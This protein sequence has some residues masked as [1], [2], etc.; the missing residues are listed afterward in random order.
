MVAIFD[1]VLTTASVSSVSK[2]SRRS[3]AFYA[4]NERVFVENHVYNSQHP[5]IVTLEIRG[6]VFFGSSMQVLSTILEKT[7]IL[8]SVQEKQEVRVLTCFVLSALMNGF[9]S[10]LRIFAN[11]TNR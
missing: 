5:K 4:P 3:L 8:L 7:G 6:A 1:F 10:N 9:S 2:V 11:A